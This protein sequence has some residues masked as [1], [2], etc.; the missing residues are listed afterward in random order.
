SLPQPIGEHLARLRRNKSRQTVNAI[1]I[2]ANQDAIFVL[3]YSPHNRCSGFFRADPCHAIEEF[4]CLYLT[5]GITGSGGAGIVG[6]VC[7]DA[8]RMYTTHGHSAAAQLLPQ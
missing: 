6:D 5:L 8:R 1:S 2:R 7:A 3:L 4:P